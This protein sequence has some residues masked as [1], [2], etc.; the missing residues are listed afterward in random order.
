MDFSISGGELRIEKKIFIREMLRPDSV[1][2]RLLNYNLEDNGKKRS[3][4]LDKSGPDNV[5][6]DFNF[7]DKVNV[8]EDYKKLLAD[9]KKEYR[10][11]IRGKITLSACYYHLM[12][13]SLD[14][15]SDDGE[16]IQSF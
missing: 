11:K 12:F 8:G 2:K 3:L 4:R 15:N 1:M 7:V 10:G 16:I 9:L 13:I 6:I 14:L 5:I